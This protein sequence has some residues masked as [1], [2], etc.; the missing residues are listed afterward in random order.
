MH[1]PHDNTRH[2]QSLEKAQI[3]KHGNLKVDTVQDGQTMFF[4]TLYF[5]SNSSQTTA[6]VKIDTGAQECTMPLSHF[7]K[8]FPQKVNSSDAL[9][10][11]ALLP[12]EKIWISHDGYHHKFLGQIILDVH[13]KTTDHTPQNFISSETP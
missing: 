1:Y 3:L 2:I 9:I 7:K 10:K 4:T 12:P 13:H 11:D 5:K 8:M 6:I